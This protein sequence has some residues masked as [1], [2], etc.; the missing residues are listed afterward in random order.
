ML[1]SIQLLQS[2][3]KGGEK[4]HWEQVRKWLEEG[5]SFSYALKKGGA[6]PYLVSLV[7][8]GEYNGQYSMC[9]SYAAD[10]YDH[11]AYWK[12]KALQQ[13]AYPVLLFLSSMVAFI[14]L[15]YR[16]LPQ[17]L[18]MYETM[19]LSPP[20][21]TAWLAERGALFGGLFL[22]FPFILWLCKGY[23]LKLPILDR[24]MRLHFSY[25]FSLQ[26]GMLLE[27]GVSIL[28]VCHLFVHTPPSLS[29][30][31]KAVFL[32]EG[33]QEGNSLSRLLQAAGCFTPEMIRFVRL[34]EEGGQL[35][36]CLLA[37]GKMAEEELKKRMENLLRW[38][39]PGLLVLLGGVV[40]LAV[41]SFFL[42]ILNMVGSFQ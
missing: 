1:E 42:P 27:S 32:Q 10:Y 9:L 29:F 21:F 12:D 22:C 37:S 16:I 26:W 20:F 17:I 34:G 13:T 4:K 38:L 31:N 41:M 30:R 2:L 15:I 8:A 19:G 28:Q 33:L 25:H 35:G 23:L 7:Q 11:R 39:E 6:S 3:I 40:L 5:N 36:K 18:D 24:W 14:F